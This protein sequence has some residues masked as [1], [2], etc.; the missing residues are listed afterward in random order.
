MKRGRILHADHH[1]GIGVVADLWVPTLALRGANL[2]LWILEKLLKAD[3]PHPEIPLGQWRCVR[4]H[5]ELQP[6]RQSGWEPGDSNSWGGGHME[7]AF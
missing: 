7:S 2:G 6:V 4:K 5:L 1:D 3:S